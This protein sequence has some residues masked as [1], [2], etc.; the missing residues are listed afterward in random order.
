MVG[1]SSVRCS[2][3]IVVWGS[4]GRMAGRP[5]ATCFGPGPIWGGVKGNLCPAVQ[6]QARWQCNIGG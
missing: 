3:T 1:V 5:E 2:L 6:P 4:L